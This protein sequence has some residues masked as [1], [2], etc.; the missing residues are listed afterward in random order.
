VTRLC[1]SPR[2]CRRRFLNPRKKSEKIRLRRSTEKL[3]KKTYRLS[4]GATTRTGMPSAWPDVSRLT[5]SAARDMF[6]PMLEL[7]GT[8]PAQPDR[9]STPLATDRVGPEDLRERIC[10]ELGLPRL[11]GFACA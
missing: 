3:I 11:L 9:I 5:L 4:I 8:L 7:V 10:A 1:R 2:A 6:P